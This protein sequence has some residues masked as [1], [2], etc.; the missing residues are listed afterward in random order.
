MNLWKVTAIASTAALSVTLGSIALAGNQPN[1]EASLV[2]LREARAA[3]EKAEHNKG[4][5]RQKAIELTDQAIVEITK[6]INYADH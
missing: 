4:G 1:M 5:H 2:K 6:G 3:L